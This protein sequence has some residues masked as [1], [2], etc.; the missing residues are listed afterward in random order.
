MARSDPFPPA[1]QSLQSQLTSIPPL[2]QSLRRITSTTSPSNPEA[3]SARADLQTALEDLDAD[4][5][6]LRDSVTAAESYAPRFGLSSHEVRGRREAVEKVGAQVQKLKESSQDYVGLTSPTQSFSGHPAYA[7]APQPS[8]PGRGAGLPDPGAFDEDE[9]GDGDAYAEF[10]QQRQEELLA[11]QDEA[12][13]GVSQTVG[14]LRAQAD[15][16]GRELE[17]QGVLI[18]EV[19]TV[20]DRVG[21]KLQ[22]GIKRVEWI[23]KKNEERWGGCCISVLI[24]VLIILLVLVL[25]L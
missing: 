24:V 19:D 12:L 5:A 3:A 4:L 14:T 15:E 2:L 21:G 25:V 20:T 10:E 9:D 11:E 22:S 18:D 23:Y 6:D 1:L 7:P 17:E 16:M 13:E 8:G